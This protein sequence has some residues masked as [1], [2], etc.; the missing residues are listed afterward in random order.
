ML[1]RGNPP[2]RILL[3]PVGIGLKCVLETAFRLRQDEPRQ[4]RGVMLLELAGDAGLA[5]NN[6]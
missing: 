1:M 2:L 3:M 4:P 6:R 5:P